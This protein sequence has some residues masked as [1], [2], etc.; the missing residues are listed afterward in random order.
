LENWLPILIFFILIILI[1][2]FAATSLIL[3]W[4]LGV[5]NPTAAKLSPS[6]NGMRPIGTARDRHS[7]QFYV[8]GAAL[9]VYLGVLPARVLDWATSSALSSLAP[10]R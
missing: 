6:E 5:R 9:T 7:V 8:S 10:F 2:G 3:S 1:A 4:F